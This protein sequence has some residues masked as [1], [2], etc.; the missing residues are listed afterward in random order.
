ML[1]N[2]EYYDMIYGLG[3]ED[4]N[5][6]RARELYWKR[7]LD[8]RLPTEQRRLPSYKCFLNMSRR[9]HPIGFFYRYTGS[10]RPRTLDARQVESMFEYFEEGPI[11]SRNKIR[12]KPYSGI[13][14]GAD[15]APRRNF[16][17][18]YVRQLVENLN[19]INYVLFVRL[20]FGQMR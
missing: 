18:W 7:F 11:T 10:R 12:Y 19:Y 4:S 14:K 6:N 3:R 13:N 15:I 5:L 20:F 9:L 2:S 17:E 8:D 16:C 1:S